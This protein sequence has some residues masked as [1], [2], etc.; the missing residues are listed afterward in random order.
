[1][2][3]ATPRVV[4]ARRNEPPPEQPWHHHL[5]ID[6]LLKVLYR[7]FLHPFIAWLIPLCLRAQLTPYHHPAFISTCIYATLLTLG[8]LAAAI[9]RR[10]AYGLAREVDFEE[11]V[12]VVTGGAGG[13]GGLVAEVYGLR[14]ATVAV[15]D[16][17]GKDSDFANEAEEK[18][19]EYYECDVSD[20]AQ[21]ERVKAQI[22]KELGT[23]TILV[24]AAAVAPM[25]PL[26]ELSAEE[27]DR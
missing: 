5:N 14:G 12:I 19:V 3:S 8:W 27:V 17:H 21:V 13:L 20:R 16:V 1:M 18:G 4:P 10:I 2:S 9:N 11:E 25:K 6:V 22:E 24:N 7:T 23:V 26:L 15:L